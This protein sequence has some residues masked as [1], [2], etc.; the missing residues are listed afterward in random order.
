MALSAP[1]QLTQGFD[2]T[3]RTTGD[4]YTTASITPTSGA[5]TLICI[6]S[7]ATI[8]AL[9]VTGAGLTWAEVAN[10]TYNTAASPADRLSIFR[11]TGTPSTGAVSIDQ[12]DSVTGCL[13]KV[14]EWT[15][16]DGTTPIVQ[17]PTNRNAGTAV[18]V[19]LSA[20]GSANNGTFIVG[21]WDAAVRTWANEGGSWT[22]VGTQ[23]SGTAPSNA[24]MASWLAGNDTTPSATL[25]GGAPDWGAIALEIAEAAGAGFVPY[26]YPRGLD[27]GMTGGMSGGM[28]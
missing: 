23:V 5:L 8:A 6:Q 17:S 1:S 14:I 21:A 20:F 2:D 25:S 9:T 12:A 15:G 19:S 28:H 3:N 26:P 22:D 27:G 13:W 16:Q 4:P 7:A 18:S 10:V 11:G 24:L